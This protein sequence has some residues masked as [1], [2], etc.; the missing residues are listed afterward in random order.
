M[1]YPYNPIAITATS[2]G[3]T[4][5]LIPFEAGAPGHFLA[6]TSGAATDVISLPSADDLPLGW[7][8]H[9]YVGANGCE[10]RTAAGTNEEINTVNADGA[11][12]TNEAALPATTMFRVTKVADIDFIL[13]ATDELG[14]VITAIV[15]G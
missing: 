3:Q 2:D 14:A 8:C 4:T 10:L 1:A 12:G 6:V 7:T 11:E 15:P 13:T 9:G 5:G